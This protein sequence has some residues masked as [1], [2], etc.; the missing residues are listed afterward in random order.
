MSDADLLE[1]FRGSDDPFLTTTEVADEV[2]IG[3]RAVY[4]RL[5]AL[6]EAGRLE[7]KS[8][9]GQT[10]TWWLPDRSG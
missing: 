3:R 6:A 7:R 10:T 9:P 1:V 8:L 2:G 5:N 4:N